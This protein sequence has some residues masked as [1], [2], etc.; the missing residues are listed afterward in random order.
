MQGT[1]WKS[2]AVLGLLVVSLGAAFF[3]Y[4]WS[5]GPRDF[6]FDLPPCFESGFPFHHRLVPSCRTKVR[7]PQ[8]RVEFQT[9]DDG[10]R[11]LPHDLVL[12]L[13]RRVLLLGDSFVEGWWLREDQALNTQLREL[14]PRQYFINAGLRG[15]GP[16]FQAPRLWHLLER[17]RPQELWVFLND[18]DVADDR[19][20]CALADKKDSPNEPARWEFRADDLEPGGVQRF[21]LDRFE[22]WRLRGKLRSLFER[23]ARNRIISTSAAESCEPCAGLRSL[24][25]QAEAKKV[26]LRAFMLDLGER[27]QRVYGRKFPDAAATL[28]GCLRELRIPFFSLKLDELTP[29]EQDKYLW[30]GDVHFNPLG[31]EYWATRIHEA[32]VPEVRRPSKKDK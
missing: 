27:G 1:N 21:L 4:L 16:L 2:Q 12:S 25:T 23:S 28:E 11:D 13:G 17:Y 30:A 5:T 10:I 26:P 24:Q 8:G 7:T 19:L 6:R 31:A 15:A 3:G 22:G 9:N 29:E 20:A 32:G 14:E 18:T